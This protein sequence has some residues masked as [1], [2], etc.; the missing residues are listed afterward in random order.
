MNN[1]STTKLEHSPNNGQEPK[2]LSSSYNAVERRQT[3]I[4]ESV[5]PYDCWHFN[6]Y[7]HDEFYAQS[8]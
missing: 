8:N 1:E 2:Q 3:F 7:E 5:V 6:I 4:I